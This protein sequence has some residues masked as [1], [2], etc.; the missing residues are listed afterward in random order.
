MQIGELSKRSGF[1]RDTIRFYE[2][3]GLIRLHDRNRNRRQFKDY[4]EGV[5]RRLL[6]IRQIKDYGF[7]L[8]ETLGVLILFE[9]G[10]LEPERGLRF[11]KRKIEGIDQKIRE[12]TAVRDRLQEVVKGHYSG[13]CPIEKILQ[14]TTI[15][16]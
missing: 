11:V 7:T 16:G 6:A 5:L 2:K 1:S 12:M 3:M 4:P 9:E 8:Q 15:Y 13:D 14:N 10:V